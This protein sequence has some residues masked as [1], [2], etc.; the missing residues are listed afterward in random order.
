MKEVVKEI[1]EFITEQKD[2]SRPESTCNTVSKIS[3]EVCQ[4][5]TQLALDNDK[6]VGKIF[7]LSKNY[8]VAAQPVKTVFT[9]AK[10]DENQGEEVK[11]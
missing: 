10:A 8:P 4:P 1:K 2:T 5:L 6:T 3:K 11:E 9:I 7:R